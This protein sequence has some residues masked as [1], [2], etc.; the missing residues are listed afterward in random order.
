[1]L[2]SLIDRAARICRLE[3]HDAFVEDMAV[4]SVR[5]G[6]LREDPRP[7]RGEPLPLD[8]LN[9][10]WVEGGS[11]RDL[12]ETVAGTAIWLDS[13]VLDDRWRPDRVDETHRRCLYAAR[14]VLRALAEHPHDWGA[15]RDFNGLLSRGHR[16]LILDTHGPATQVV[17]DEPHWVVPW[18]AGET[19]LDLLD[20]VPDRI[21]QCQHPQCVLWYLDTSPSATR[22]W[23]SMTV[24]GNRAKA[25]RHYHRKSI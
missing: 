11:E 16:G 20:R 24:C 15:R 18:L 6:G 12:L 9:T 25:Q 19:Y 5:A 7:L 13:A 23:C 21:R 4:T 14:G 17:V 8:L 22:R 10:T 3:C 1:M 2:G